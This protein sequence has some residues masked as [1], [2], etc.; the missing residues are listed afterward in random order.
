MHNMSRRMVLN[1]EGDPDPT[2][3]GGPGGDAPA[4]PAPP[5]WVPADEFKTF[6]AT[7]NNTLGAITDTLGYLRDA[8]A[9]GAASS[10]S[11]G[12]TAP[13][14]TPI[15]DQQF[16][17]ACQTGDAGTISAYLKQRE[18]ALEAE[19]ITPLRN[20]GL[21]AIAGLT[22]EHVTSTLPYYKRWQKEIDAFVAQMPAGVRLHADVYRT[23]HN[24]VV[25][26]HTSELIAEATEAAIRQANDPKP[27]PGRPSVQPGRQRG[28]GNEVPTVEEYMGREAADALAFKGLS[29]DDFARKL[30][31]YKNWADYVKQTSEV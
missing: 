20:T 18:A 31:R 12:P 21:E 25:G 2:A 9:R 14:G 28:T 3:D 4:P 24:A 8:A 17:E 11:P 27:E 13:A 16:A 1:I 5:A 15:S 7:V 23:A 30:G 6:Q 22:K 10:A 19:H 29:P 26:Q